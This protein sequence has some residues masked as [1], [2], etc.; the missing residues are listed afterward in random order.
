MKQRLDWL[1]VLFL[2]TAFG[3]HASGGTLKQIWEFDLKQVAEEGP[4]SHHFD[5]LP[6]FSLRFSPDGRRIAV[7]AG[8]NETRPDITGMFVV[9]TER[10]E[11]NVSRFEVHGAA[12]QQRSEI[13]P[14]FMWSPTGNGIIFN[15]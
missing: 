6:I 14:S 1:I 10:P 11:K 4:G 5:V 12:A 13:A 3:P 7:L 2:I 15:T 8:I 9:P